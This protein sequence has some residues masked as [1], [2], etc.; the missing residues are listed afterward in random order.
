LDEEGS[1]ILGP[2]CQS[3]NETEIWSWWLLNCKEV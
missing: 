1:G 2:A 3:R